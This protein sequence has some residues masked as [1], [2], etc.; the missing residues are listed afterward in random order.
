[1]KNSG[2]MKKT[3]TLLLLLMSVTGI[4]QSPYNQRVIK[5]AVIDT[6]FDFNSDWNKVGADQD[7]V[8]LIKPKLCKEGHKDFTNTGIVDRHG[9]GT[10]VAGIIAKFAQ[11]A[12]YCLVIIKYY[13]PTRQEGV[14]NL[15]SSIKAL[16]YAN[17]IGVDVVNYSGGG[18]EFSLEEYKAV[19]KLLDKGTIFV[20]AAGNESTVTDYKLFKMDLTSGKKYFINTK[21]G[22]ITSDYVAS[23][24][25]AGYDPRIISVGNSTFN[26][27]T[28]KVETAKTSNR[29]DAIN[30]EENGTNV[31]SILPNN[32]KGYMTGTSQSAPTKLGKMLKIWNQK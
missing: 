14:S 2:N 22:D 6:G 30:F 27:K 4:A 9:H 29:G 25:P 21:T 7:G 20:A 11:N 32:K 18:L 1:M 3:L 28:K 17:Q 16:Q 19:K 23:Y 8:K 10:H 26:H 24:Y 15:E 31:I 13:D 12:N 5:V